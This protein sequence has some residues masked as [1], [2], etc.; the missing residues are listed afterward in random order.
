LANAGR[1]KTA[2]LRRGARILRRF[3]DFKAL[4]AK[5]RN[6]ANTV[7]GWTAAKLGDRN[8]VTGYQ[9]QDLLVWPRFFILRAWT[10][11]DASERHRHAA[12]AAWRDATEIGGANYTGEA[13]PA[14]A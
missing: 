8:S 4:G 2:R 5:K 12:M 9:L 14:P 1:T 11:S 7:M 6:L 10:G 3:A 13:N